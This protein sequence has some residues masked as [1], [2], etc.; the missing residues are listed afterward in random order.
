MIPVGLASS[1]ALKGMRIKYY[2]EEYVYGMGRGGIQ[3]YTYAMNDDEWS[4][5]VKE[6]GG[7]LDYK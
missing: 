6:Q 7:T 5:Y 1:A 2:T 4:N 3:Y